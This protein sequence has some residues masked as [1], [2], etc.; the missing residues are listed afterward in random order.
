MSFLRFFIS[1]PFFTNI[2]LAL[3][4][5]VLMLLGTFAWLNSSTRHGESLAVPDIR[6][7]SIEKAVQ[8][9]ESKNLRYQIT[10]SVFFPDKAKNAIID[11]NP[12][13]K[14]R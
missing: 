4:V 13:P 3:V 7:V 1:K 9:L 10:D 8:L 14:R 12:M 6:G 2:V 5:L 11:Q